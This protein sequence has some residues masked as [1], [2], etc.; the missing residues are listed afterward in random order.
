[1]II[2]IK[3]QID[4]LL[5]KMQVGEYCVGQT[6]D[7]LF[8]L[9]LQNIKDYEQITNCKSMIN[10]RQYFAIQCMQGILSNKFTQEALVHKKISSSK[11]AVYCA[12]EIL[13]ELELP[14]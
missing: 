11:F 10:V 13:Q 14:K 3:K 9:F 8:D 4:D 2:S 7:K 12:D 6:S 1:M 5:F